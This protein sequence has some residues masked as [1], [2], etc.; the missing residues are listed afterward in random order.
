[1]PATM[2]KWILTAMAIALASTVGGASAQQ[3]ARQPATQ[4]QPAEPAKDYD[5]RAL[6][7]YEFRKAA[8]S[9]PHRG[10]EIYYYKCW[11]C[12]NELAQ[13]GAPKLTGLFTRPMLVT[14][15]PVSDESVKNQIRNGSPNM[16]AYKYALNE[17]DLDDLVSWLHDEKCCWNNDAPPPNPRY[18]AAAA[19]PAQSLYASLTG[20]PKGLVKNARGEPIEGIMV[21]LIADDSAIRTTVFSRTDGRYEFPKVAAGSYTLRIAKPKEFYPWS[22]QKVAIKGADT[23]EDITLLAGDGERVPAAVPGDRGAAHRLGM[24]AEPAR[25]R[26]GE[27]DA[28]GL[29]QL[30]PR[31]SA[32]LPQPL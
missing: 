28:A 31:I 25:H 26:R 11:M 32:D 21:Q 7:I 6:E 29:L 2:T 9:G 3:Q 23:L 22:K 24:A 13:G 12:H 18:K 1:M 19:A 16:G 4:A 8:Q 20:G 14:G 27:E 30:L 17:A 10:Q 5:Q 15:A